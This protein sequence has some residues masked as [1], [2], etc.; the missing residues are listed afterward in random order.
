MVDLNEIEAQGCNFV[1]FNI[2]GDINQYYAPHPL[3]GLPSYY[4]FTFSK[5]LISYQNSPTCCK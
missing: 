2:N 5:F 4:H 3:F 1:M